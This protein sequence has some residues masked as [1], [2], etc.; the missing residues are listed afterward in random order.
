M[1]EITIS[2]VFSA[3]H[4]IRLYDGTLEPIHGHDWSVEVTVGSDQLDGM[5]TVMD[6]HVLEQAVDALLDGW[7]NRSLN[8]CPPFAPALPGG[9]LAINTTAERVAQV[10]GEAA[11]SVLPEGVT[12]RWVRVGEAPGCFATYR[13][14]E[15]SPR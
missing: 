2:R 15:S 10:V 13:P 7:Q 3:A 9:P 14:A 8:E 1:Y 12:L 6:F 4:A 11:A 5:D